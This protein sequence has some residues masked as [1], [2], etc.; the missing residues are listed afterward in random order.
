MCGA[1]RRQHAIHSLVH[2][3]RL[4]SDHKASESALHYL[5]DA[6]V[7]QAGA[8]GVAVFQVTDDGLALLTSRGLPE[9]AQTWKVENAAIGLATSAHLRSLV[10]ANQELRASREALARAEKL[11]ALGQMA[12]GVSHDLK[13]ILNPISLHLQIAARRN[14]RG[15]SQK[16]GESLDEMKQVLKRGLDVIERLR[17]FSPQAPGS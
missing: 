6:L 13:N 11:R 1:M 7:D 9:S 10:N 14:A 12:A 4:V 3:A 5:T 17:E 15:E 16:V 8:D 2:L